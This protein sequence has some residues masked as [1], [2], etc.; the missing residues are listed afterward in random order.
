M[1]SKVE[2]VNIFILTIQL[3][4]L[5]PFHTSSQILYMRCFIFYWAL[6][7]KVVKKGSRNKIILKAGTPVLENVFNEFMEL[8]YTNTKQIPIVFKNQNYVYSENLILTVIL[9]L[10]SL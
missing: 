6:K 2:V 4:S 9:R 8:E 1:N 7:L 5:G 3:N 10:T